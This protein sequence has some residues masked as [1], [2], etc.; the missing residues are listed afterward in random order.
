M[1]F[2]TPMKPV[3]LLSF[4]ICLSGCEDG[5]ATKKYLRDQATTFTES[6]NMTDVFAACVVEQTVANY[7][8]WY[9]A[10]RVLLPAM[11]S[12]ESKRF[13]L[14]F[15]EAQKSC[16]SNMPNQPRYKSE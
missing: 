11:K 8:L 7:S 12:N 13:E 10:K 5:S 16:M 9:R 1:L 6:L 14:W 2:L 15:V 4:A 3:V